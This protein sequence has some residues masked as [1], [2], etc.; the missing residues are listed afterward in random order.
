MT[1]KA[2]NWPI[3]SK[4]A[5][6]GQTHLDPDEASLSSMTRATGQICLI[7]WYQYFYCF[8]WGR[9]GI[10]IN[11]HSLQAIMLNFILFRLFDLRF[12][13][14]VHVFVFVFLVVTSRPSEWRYCCAIAVLS[15]S[16]PQAL[17]KGLICPQGGFGQQEYARYDRAPLIF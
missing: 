5:T 10:I 13:R 8:L 12:N 2:L 9:L 3:S 6:C 1:Q 7:S 15:I 17:R 16:R 11:Y 4:M 14:M